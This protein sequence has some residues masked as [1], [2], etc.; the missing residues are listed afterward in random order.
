MESRKDSLAG[1]GSGPSS[2]PSSP[3]PSTKVRSQSL[4]IVAPLPSVFITPSPETDAAIPGGSSELSSSNLALPLGNAAKEKLT[5]K[6]RPRLSIP[7]IFT[8]HPSGTS[9]LTS[10]HSISSLLTAAAARNFT[11]N[12]PHSMRRG[13]WSVSLPSDRT[14]ITHGPLDSCSHASWKHIHTV[15]CPTFQHWFL[16]SVLQ[17]DNKEESS[18]I[19]RL[20]LFAF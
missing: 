3:A 4:T 6:N 12:L 14:I 18:S 8:H 2:S 13:S 15:Y 9:P 7:Q 20:I 19:S 10:A 1:T 16:L 5:G 17:I 11:F